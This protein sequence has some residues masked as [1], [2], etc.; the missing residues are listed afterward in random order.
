MDRRLV[1]LLVLPAL[2]VS[3][4]SRAQPEQAKHDHADHDHGVARIL[5]NRVQP[6]VIE[7]DSARAVTW[8]NYSRQR[9][10]V[11]FDRGVAKSLTCQSKGSFRVDGERL[12]SNAIQATQF[13]SLCSLAPG[14][15]EYRVDLG[16]GIGSSGGPTAVKSF[17]G[18]IVVSE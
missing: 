4:S 10:R 6:A 17:T 5:E 3:L 18:K 11:S 2:F 16:T 15:Y 8:L 9:A 13:A 7:I 14:E 12:T 1:W